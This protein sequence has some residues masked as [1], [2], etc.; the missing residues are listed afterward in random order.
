MRACI[1]APEAS[2]TQHPLTISRPLA[3]IPVANTPLRQLQL[4]ALRDAGFDTS[5]RTAPLP[6][7]LT[8][9]TA[10]QPPTLLIRGDAWF[11]PQL[12]RHLCRHPQTIRQAMPFARLAGHPPPAHPTPGPPLPSRP[13][14]LRY[15]W[16]LLEL[17]ARLLDAI[18]A[19]DTPVDTACWNAVAATWPP[20]ATPPPTP[21]LPGVHVDG[22]L[23][24]G[25]GTRFLPGVYI[26][27]T[28]LIGD[29]CLIGPNCYLRGPSAIGSRCRIGQ[30][31]E[32]KASIL[33]DHVHA[34]HLSYVGD[35]IIGEHANLG[36]G[37]VTA[38]FRHD[39]KNHRSMVA[40]R[41]VDT[42]RNKFGTIIGDHVHTAIHTAIYPGR[43]LWPHTS[44]LPGS[45]VQRDITTE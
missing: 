27:G 6:S 2:E 44:T 8:D 31:V 19:P 36:C 7:D 24:Y 29:H 38:N 5:E 22:R 41:L 33:M 25:P 12:L 37:T 11:P 21:A 9:R 16:D 32:I 18:D 30:G 20:T 42:G 4:R 40:G 26:E 15:P 17:N 28:V 14:H 35:S 39:G 43:K 13:L 23:Y 10:Q 45:I 34:A 3:A 1:T